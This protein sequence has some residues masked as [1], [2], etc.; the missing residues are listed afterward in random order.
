MR[1]EEHNSVSM[2]RSIILL[3]IIC[4]QLNKPEATVARTPNSIR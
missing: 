1:K 2:V 3:N 4:P